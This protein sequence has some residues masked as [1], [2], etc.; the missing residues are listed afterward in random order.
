MQNFLHFVLDMAPLWPYSGFAMTNTP[1]IN[2]RFRTRKEYDQIRREA[3]KAGQSLNS[4]ILNVVNASLMVIG[5]AD[6]LKENS[7]A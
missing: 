7:R 5:H 6:R 4:F 2:L 1:K 3:K